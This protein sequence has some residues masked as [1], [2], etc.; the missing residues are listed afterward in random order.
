MSKVKY[1]LAGEARQN[2]GDYLSELL[3]QRLFYDVRPDD[4][5]IRIIGS[6][7]HDSF[8][9][10]SYYPDDGPAEPTAVFWGCGVRESDGL[11]EEG[12][13]RADIRAVRGPISA[14]VLRLG[15]DVATGDP[16]LLLPALY[17]PRERPGF[18][19]KSVCI[20]HFLDE[21]TDLEILRECGADIVLRPNIPI[22]INHLLSFVDGLTSADFVLS[23]SLHGAIVAAAYQRKFA[24]W[25]SETIDLPLKW[26]D[27]SHSVGI[28]TAFVHTV[29]AGRR[30][31]VEEIEKR[32]LLPNTLPLLAAAP[33]PLKPSGLVAVLRFELERTAPRQHAE[34][35]RDFA[36]SLTLYQKDIDSLVERSSALMKHHLGDDG[37]FK[38]S[39]VAIE[40][41]LAFGLRSLD[42]PA[43]EPFAT[44]EDK[45]SALLAKAQDQRSLLERQAAQLENA[46]QAAQDALRVGTEREATLSEQN[47]VL[48]NE[49]ARV[50]REAGRSAAT[51]DAELATLNEQ[52][53]ALNNKI[54]RLQQD[55]AS[56]AADN[57]HL[58]GQLTEFRAQNEL[59]SDELR[60]AKIRVDAAQEEIAGRAQVEANSSARIAELEEGHILLREQNAS[61]AGR[62]EA[63]LMEQSSLVTEKSSLARQLQALRE[64]ARGFEDALITLR[65]NA[66]KLEAERDSWLK[67]A[68]QAEL[69]HDAAAYG[70]ALAV[71]QMQELR[72][73]HQVLLHQERMRSRVLLRDLHGAKGQYFHA[74]QYDAGITN[75]DRET[76]ESVAANAQRQT[77]SI[78]LGRLSFRRKKR[79]KPADNPDRQ[80]AISLISQSGLFDAGWYAQQL[81]EPTEDADELLHHY[82]ATG[83]Q[84][85]ISPH[86]L[87]DT[88]H[89]LEQH[90]EVAT[91][92]GTPLE[93]YL[94]VGWKNGWQPHLLFDPEY[95]LEQQPSAAISGI[96]PLCD[97]LVRGWRDN[98]QPHPFFDPAFYLQE[99]SDV[100][101]YECEPLGH[102]LMSGWQD[103]L[104]PHPLI[105]IEQ[106]LCENPD[107]AAAGVEP[108]MHYLR[109]GRNEK[110]RLAP[111]ID[112][113]FYAA[114][115]AAI[116][117]GA[118]A[119][120][121]YLVDGRHL[122]FKPNALFDPIYYSAKANANLT[123]E[124]ALI[125]YASVGWQIGTPPSPLFDP[126]Y[127]LA[128]NPDVAAIGVEPLTHYLLHG[129]HE[130]R[131]PHPV[132]DIAGYLDR[133]PEL[134]ALCEEPMGHYLGS[135]WR[136]NRSISLLFDTE[137]YREQRG[138]LLLVDVDPLSDYLEDGW[139]IGMAPHPLFDANFYRAQYMNTDDGSVDPL[140][141]FMTVGRQQQYTGHPLFDAEFY[142]SNS[143]DIVRSE[144]N[145]FLH[146][147]V[148]GGKEGRSP[149]SAFQAA[150]YNFDHPDVS[151][152]A[153]NALIHYLRRGREAG[154]SPHPL[155][156]PVFYLSRNLDVQA[157][158]MDPYEHFVRFGASEGRQ[159]SEALIPERHPIEA[160][161][162]FP[163]VVDPEVT[164]IIPVYRS[165]ADTFR[166]LYSISETFAREL[167][168]RI[169]IADDCPVSPVAPFFDQIPNL[170]LITNSINYGFLRNCN[171][172][173]AQTGGEF[174][175]F[176][177]ND[178]VVRPGWLDSLINLARRDP[179]T[180]L[181]G[182]KLLNHDGSIQEAGGVMFTDGWGYPYGR[183]DRSNR[184]EY[185]FVRQVDC[186]IGACFLVRRSA[187]EA[188][189]GFDD[190]YAPAF[191]EEFDLAMAIA[192]AGYKVLY[193][194][195]SEIFHLGSASYGA[196]VRDRQSR[197]NQAKFKEKWASQL[198]GRYTGPQDL[199]LARDRRYLSGTILIIDDLVP[200]FDKHAGALTMYQYMKLM[201]EL[202]FKVVYL[203]HDRSATQPYTSIYQQMGIEILYGDFDFSDWL[204]ANGRYLDWVWLARPDIARA[205]VDV[206]RAKTDAR[207]VYYTHD[208]HFL[209]EQ[210][211]YEVEGEDWA[212]SE[213]VRL[214]AIE[215]SLF[216]RVDC[217]MT[218][219]AEEAKVIAKLAPD[220]TIQ[221]LTPYF[222]DEPT[223]SCKPAS[224]PLIKR[225][226]IIFVGGYRHVPN[227]DAAI[228]LV[229]NIMPKV[230]A[231]VP[232]AKV[233]LLGSHP[234]QEVIELGG[235]KVTVLGYVEDLAPYYARAR[236]S[237]SPLRYGAGV[238]GKIVSS[239]EAGVPVVSTS[240]GNEG[241]ALVHGVDAMIGDT[242][243]ELADHVVRLFADDDLLKSLQTA[244]A[245]VIHKRFSETLAR[246]GLLAA[247]DLSICNVCGSRQHPRI[248]NPA[249]GNWRE[250]PA[251]PACWSLNRMK[252][253]ADVL[254]KPY[255]S[256]KV[257]SI[258]DALPFL[259]ELRIHEFGFV[260]PIHDLLA[261]LPQFSASDFFDD[262]PPG[263]RAL[264]G[265]MC[266]DIQKLTFPDEELDL[267]ISQDVF[268][269]LPDPWQGF[270]EI[271][272]VLKTSGRHIFTIPYSPNAEHSI[273]RATLD[274]SG[275]RYVLPAEYHGDPIRG[276]AGALVFTDFGRD[277]F[278][279]LEAMGFSVAMTEVQLENVGGGYTVVFS[280]IKTKSKPKEILRVSEAPDED[281]SVIPVA[282]PHD[283]VMRQKKVRR[284]R[285]KQ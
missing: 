197:I 24:F 118:D 220:T 8:I 112:P 164:V 158:G 31:Y 116:D 235:P 172:A 113:A 121:H 178:T 201:T 148:T 283:P 101:D 60:T 246:E 119:V 186:V 212:L 128:A 136:E 15:V 216:Q 192:E 266:Q 182:C 110:R 125:H 39:R 38:R 100:R 219:S 71:T 115:N 195:A 180:A 275:L 162:A 5:E 284:A 272:R 252:F 140:V 25:R 230:W 280:T 244:G 55:A 265:V 64:S 99:N 262:V 232:D 274:D 52:H 68:T 145:A 36:A 156:D 167:K 152:Y 191:F 170:E 247:L 253:L 165:F 135:G 237:V 267:C 208:L 46:T 242:V 21:R 37:A 176:L 211:R 103:K 62:I 30:V 69:D 249:T 83:G 97:Y 213:S 11:S 23:A 243:A 282:A 127:Y 9:P 225:R 146:Y 132:I 109:H 227:V 209:R 173:A 120:M 279:R 157:I 102:Y 143:P 169:V 93:H 117:A 202:D 245:A 41:L 12:R 261:Q 76:G 221:V 27:F 92:S 90:P 111:L 126:T 260:G 174:I 175:V 50:Q 138:R 28:E 79:V 250:E 198:A 256:S 70:R 29:D 196:E 134:Y 80:R 98:L 137:Y 73:A 255:R 268:E 206:V 63:L 61:L 269:H 248:H 84:S 231:V 217:V 263:E 56:A 254:L 32:I 226:E 40:Q 10:G 161:I 34:L 4:S 223:L 45:L 16:G 203:P 133:N 185:N 240:I 187:F 1:W 6:C 214:K 190:R 81:E 179:R 17:C 86:P 271:Y 87:F 141:H 224:L 257:S 159:A 194:P 181:I 236:L 82:V 44:S 96:P 241:I 14:D 210:R 149:N 199:F 85:G 91:Y 144:Q 104:Q 48:N 22:G 139:K 168:T 151:D 124:N 51:H 49:M 154:F 259:G 228:L 183:G 19:G 95:Y 67:R 207:L 43:E 238:K 131:A 150:G 66:A 155:F 114:T 65:Q 88:S 47:R 89:Y 35:L 53:R 3:M 166:C 234:P 205:Y 78:F 107:L 26:D 108:L 106:Y 278:R 147:I 33:F 193:Q 13:K 75:R 239:L 18:S 163:S 215:T 72:R 153:G 171:Q 129:W 188:V 2:F 58:A 276:E 258:K 59:F 281:E 184:P 222:F 233:M 7:I 277:I 130:R 94:T 160:S 42:V 105:N 177:N 57:K 54:S 77:G 20:P 229:R 123:Y 270:R 285:R 264:N 200:E 204:D 74:L 251:C 218:P 122:G 142:L 273:V 189:G